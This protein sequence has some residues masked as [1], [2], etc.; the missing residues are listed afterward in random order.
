MWHYCLPVVPSQRL[1]LCRTLALSRSMPGKPQAQTNGCCLRETE[2]PALPISIFESVEILA[3][4]YVQDCLKRQRHAPNRHRKITAPSDHGQR[5]IS[6]PSDLPRSKD[7]SKH[8]R[9]LLRIL[10]CITTRR[11]SLPSLRRRAVRCRQGKEGSNVRVSLC[12]SRQSFVLN[13]S[14]YTL[15]L[16]V[17]ACDLAQ[18]YNYSGFESHVL[19]GRSI[20]V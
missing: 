15:S 1:L 4:H 13:K 6:H 10:L 12:K 20:Y 17:K 2:T 9:I 3:E 16:T 7:R 19:P 18:L 5:C 11:S 14:D 8:L